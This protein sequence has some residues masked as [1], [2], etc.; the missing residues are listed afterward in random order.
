V[1]ATVAS[2]G[3]PD[4]RNHVNVPA[5]VTFQVVDPGLG[6]TAKGLFTG[7]LRGGVRPLLEWTT[8]WAEAGVPI[9]R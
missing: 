5:I 7:Q 6:D 3:G 2:L 4:L 9:R 8:S 1:D